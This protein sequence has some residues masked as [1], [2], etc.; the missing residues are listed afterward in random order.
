MLLALG[1]GAYLSLRSQKWLIDNKKQV[2]KFYLTT[3]F[4]ILLLIKKNMKTEYE[5]HLKA[6][7]VIE[8]GIITLTGYLKQCKEKVITE[9]LKNRDKGEVI[10]NIVLAQRDLESAL[11]RIGKAGQ[12]ID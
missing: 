4:E 5:H 8:E 6:L 7:N 11:F 12:Q 2:I 9:E 10:A 1:H 3:Q